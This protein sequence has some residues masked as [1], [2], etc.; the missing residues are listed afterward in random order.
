MNDKLREKISQFIDNELSRDESLE[1]LKKIQHQPE[2]KDVLNRYEA[3]D[4]AIKSQAFISLR[5]DFSD[6]ISREI[7]LDNRYK[8]PQA[9]VAANMWNH[10][11][12]AL[13]ASLAIVS[14]IIIRSPVSSTMESS[15]I[16]TSKTDFPMPVKNPES[17]PLNAQI[18]DYVQAHNNNGYTN[19]EA[20]V[21]LSSYSRK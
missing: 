9:K 7:N 18:Y 1:L 12:I 17:K 8:R 14:V 15:S 10:N 6:R 19:E 16:Q 13:A 21:R 11:L 5:A 20:F 3:I 4:Y 2:L